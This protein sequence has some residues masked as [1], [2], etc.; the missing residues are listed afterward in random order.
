MWSYSSKPRYYL[1]G[2]VSQRSANSYLAWPIH[3]CDKSFGHSSQWLVL[4]VAPWRLVK[5]WLKT[6][7]IA[8]RLLGSDHLAC[9]FPHYTC[10]C[11][12]PASECHRLPADHDIHQIGLS[13]SSNSL[14]LNPC[15]KKLWLRTLVAFKNLERQAR[16]V[17]SCDIFNIKTKKHGGIPS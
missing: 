10:D 7:S 3:W 6:C 15:Q 16:W 1:V 17:F 8:L 2:K 9:G 14:L 13:R 4:V 12:S 11:R 5:I